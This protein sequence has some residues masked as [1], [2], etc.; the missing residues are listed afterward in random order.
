MGLRAR[1]IYGN[2]YLH[3][4]LRVW[5]SVGKG[6]G[7]LKFTCRL[8]VPI[9]KHRQITQQVLGRLAERVV[10]AARKMQVRKDSD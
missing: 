1:R 5:V 9:T 3:P 7:A 8:P 4:W 10:F 6:A 2:L